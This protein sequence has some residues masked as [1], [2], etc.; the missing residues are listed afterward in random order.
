MENVLVMEYVLVVNTKFKGTSLKDVFFKGTVPKDVFFPVDERHDRLIVEQAVSKFGLCKGLKLDYVTKSIKN[1]DFL[2]YA[3]KAQSNVVHGLVTVKDKSNTTIYVEVLCGS[4]NP[5]VA[6]IGTRLLELVEEI[7]KSMNK[8]TI[9]LDAGAGVVRFY[10]NRGYVCRG[11]DGLCNLE[12]KIQGGGKQRGRT[13]RTKALRRN[14]KNGRRLT[15][16]S[17][18]RRD[19]RSG[20]SRHSNPKL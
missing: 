15:H 13:F 3:Q 19:R 4:P 9:E 1:C 16:K 2:I 18:N 20:N 7:G 6:G 5:K 17:Q 11:D 10:H 12:R 8:T 14:K